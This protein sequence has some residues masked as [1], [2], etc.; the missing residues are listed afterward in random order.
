MREVSPWRL[1]SDAAGDTSIFDQLDMYENG[2]RAK[3]TSQLLKMFMD[4]VETIDPLLWP[5]SK[6]GAWDDLEPVK[7]KP[8]TYS[9]GNCL[10]PNPG[11]KC[12]DI[13]NAVEADAIFTV[14]PLFKQIG[15]NCVELERL[16]YWSAYIWPRGKWEKFIDTA[17]SKVDK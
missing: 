15:V 4:K 7:H 1:Y 8:R 9:K 6:K 17:C 2:L 5:R 12:S 3:T 13:Q 10:F 11:G 14:I 16:R